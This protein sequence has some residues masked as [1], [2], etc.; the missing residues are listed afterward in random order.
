[1]AAQD[2]KVYLIDSNGKG[3]TT[4]GSGEDTPVG[5][6]HDGKYVLVVRNGSF[7]PNGPGPSLWAIPV[8]AGNAQGEPV[9]VHRK[10]ESDKWEGNAAR[11][12]FLG[13]TTFGALYYSILFTTDTPEIWALENFL[14][15]SK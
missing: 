10:F 2:G 14:P 5:W 4:I 7:S 15:P 3:E 11:V 13:V 12:Q 9:M 1:M 6:S 8:S